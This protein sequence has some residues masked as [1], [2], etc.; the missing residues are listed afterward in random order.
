MA[1][2]VLCALRLLGLI[3]LQVHSDDRSRPLSAV[4]SGLSAVAGKS[5]WGAV[6]SE[7]SSKQNHSSP[8]SATLV[9]LGALSD[10]PCGTAKQD[11]LNFRPY[12]EALAFLI[13]WKRSE[14][15][16]TTAI[17]APWGAGKTSLSRQVQEQLKTHGD[18]ND[19]H[20]I[21]EF[22]AWKHDDAPNLLGAVDSGVVA[23]AITPV[24]VRTP[25][26]VGWSVPGSPCSVMVRGWRGPRRA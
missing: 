18:W 22:S 13:D 4:G 25:C 1:D 14:P 9:P 20:I 17:N 21:C 7:G 15:P 11:H 19:D 8:E 12:A 26:R 3:P 23:Y 10:A 6:V 24:P 5:A 16:L 2:E